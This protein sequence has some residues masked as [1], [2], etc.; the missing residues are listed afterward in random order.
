M[1]AGPHQPAGTAGGDDSLGPVHGQT[2]ERGHCRPFQAVSLCRRLR[3]GSPAPTGGGDQDHRLLPQQGQEPQDLLSG[4]GGKAW[5]PG[6]ADDGG[7]DATGRRGAQDGQCGAG[8]RLWRQLRRGGGYTRGPAGA[9]ARHN[10]GEGP[11]ED[12]AGVDEAGAAGAVD[13]AQ[14]LADL[15]WPPPLLRAQ[16]RLP[17]LRGQGPLPENWGAVSRE[18]L[19]SFE[20]STP[21][22]KPEGRNPK[23]AEIRILRTRHAAGRR[24]FSDA[25]DRAAPYPEAAAFQLSD[26]GLRISFGLRPSGFGV[27]PQ[28]AF[29]P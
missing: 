23:E 6:A 26:F 7:I 19:L 2:R 20:R 24:L 10:E 13:D 29:T 27:R 16:A 11:R 28:G 8:Q 12:R 17:G 5:W 15:A 4:S 3:T 1:R 14:S 9:A 21:N 25:I 18:W 22:P